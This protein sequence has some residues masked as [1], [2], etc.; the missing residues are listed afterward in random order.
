MDAFFLC[1]EL[2]LI[3]RGAETT[4]LFPHVNARNI[5]RVD[6]VFQQALSSRPKLKQAGIAGD[7]ASELLMKWDQ[8]PHL[9]LLEGSE[10]TGMTSTPPAEWASAAF[11][12]DRYQAYLDRNDLPP[13][14]TNVT[15]FHDFF[16]ERRVT[17]AR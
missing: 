2:L 6:H 7:T 9:Q 3:V 5:H 17:L 11:M 12:P 8:L 1:H 13:L 4:R 16:T 10:N 15:K 14:P